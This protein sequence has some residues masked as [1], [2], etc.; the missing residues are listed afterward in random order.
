MT[1]PAEFFRPLLACILILYLNAER[2]GVG[3]SWIPAHPKMA[4]AFFGTAAG[5]LGG[6]VNVMLP[7]LVILALE[8][9]M[10]KT[11]MIQ[12][13]NLCFLTGKLT[14]AAVLLTTGHFTAKILQTSLV[15]ALVCPLIMILAMGFRNRIRGKTHRKWM[16]RLLALMSGV[17]LIQTLMG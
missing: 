12:V 1:A 7:A 9:K 13:F 5:L 2:L 3:F 14:Q 17:L 11:A 4:T 8:I 16:R 15:L 10:D 6:T